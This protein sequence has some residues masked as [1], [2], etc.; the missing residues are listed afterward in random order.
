VVLLAGL[1][2]ERLGAR[3]SGQWFA[4]AC[5]AMCGFV[6]AVG[7]LLSTATTL[8][9]GSVVISYLV[10]RLLQGADRRLWGVVGVVGGITFQANVLIGFLL[11]ALAVTLRA[12]AGAVVAGAVA[13]L[14]GVPYLV[15]QGKHGWPQLDVAH[16]I[17]AGHSGSSVS[18]TVFLLFLFLQIGPWLT[19][20]WMTGLVRLL[21]DGTLRA[22]GWAFLLLTV[23]FLIL[24]GKPYYLSGL[25]PLL[26]AAGAQ[27]AVDWL[28]SWGPSALLVLSTPVLVFTLPLLPAD[29][30]GW[31]LAV[32]PDAGETIGWQ[33]FAHQVMSAV[34]SGAPVLT[35]NYAQAGALQR[36]T[37][38]R[39]YSGHNGY[40]SWGVPPGSAPVLLVGMPTTFCA[41]SELVGRVKMPVDNQENGTSLRTCVPSA[42]WSQLWSKIRHY[43]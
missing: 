20:V 16:S 40:A 32:N 28:A 36:Y 27:P 30:V 1:I 38:L 17:A 7:H 21:R 22:F 25:V 34:P 29:D 33:H 26:L 2:A 43:S 23:T 41:S 6:L 35:R 8:L 9:L 18:R 24:G 19:P 10:L 4:A 31:V 3:R 13:L 39:V 14:M 12:R 15:W 11:L 42:S 37:S 5:T